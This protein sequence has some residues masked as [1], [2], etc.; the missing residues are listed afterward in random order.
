[1][2]S[3]TVLR[4]PG[5]GPF[6]LSIQLHGCGGPRPFLK[7]YAEAAVAAGVAVIIID[8]FTPRGFSRLDGSLLVCTGAALQG[9]LRAGDL[10]AVYDWAQ[11]QPWVDNRRIVA[12]GWSHGGWTIMDGLAAGDR[13]GRLTR[14]SDLPAHPL[15]GLAGA[16]LIY[17]YA[18]FPAMTAGRGWGEAKPKVGALLCGRDQV[19]GVRFPERAIER[20]ER[21]GVPVQRLM[22]NDATHAFDE[23]LPSDPRTKFRPDLRDQATAWYV[24]Q[25]QRAIA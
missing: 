14:L 23:D 12:T 19:V 24:E 10:Y 5:P 7:T 17:P 25:L 18:G 8:S 16:I 15:A 9:S 6:P 22:L 1:M 11:R 2:K 3:A 4:P 20:L 21:D 13:A